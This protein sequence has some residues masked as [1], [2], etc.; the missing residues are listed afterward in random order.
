MNALESLQSLRSVR[1][2]LDWARIPL[3]LHR[4][5]NIHDI[6]IIDSK[7]STDSGNAYEIYR[8]LGKM[9]SRSPR[10]IGIDIQRG[11]Y[12]S[13]HA[14][15]SASLHQLFWC[16]PTSRVPLRLN[17]LVMGRM[18]VKLDRLTLP[19]FHHLK[20]LDLSHMLEPYHMPNINPEYTY[21]GPFSS[22]CTQ[23]HASQNLVGSS[24]D[25]IWLALTD[26]SVELE[27]IKVRKVTM[28]LLSYLET[29]CGV[30][31]LHALSSSSSTTPAECDE[32]ASRFFGTSLGRHA[33]TIDALD[34]EAVNDGL[35]CFGS[36]NMTVIASC[37]NLLSLGI[38]M[39]SLLLKA[40]L[41]DAEPT[42]GSE[43]PLQVDKFD[44]IVGVL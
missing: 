11:D 20:S 39:S 43:P 21:D 17:R 41:C 33:Q 9:I 29:Y 32:L 40:S 2:E 22:P 1:I 19:H 36:H 28:G 8:N 34:I 4:L 38:T 27:V 26:L 18:F 14:D 6:T 15:I 37:T 24:I 5:R 7:P 44:P 13:A 31:K 42:L 10:L 16:Y 3:P 30:K 23:L 35:W 25:D 12:D